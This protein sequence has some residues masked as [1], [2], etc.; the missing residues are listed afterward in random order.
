MALP[1]SYIWA[2]NNSTCRTKIA[3]GNVWVTFCSHIFCDPCGSKIFS[4]MTCIS[5]KSDVSGQ[6]KLHKKSLE[7]TVGWKKMVL[8]GLPPDTIMEICTSAIQFYYYQTTHQVSSMNARNMRLSERLNSVRQYY[9]G[10]V[11]QF[12]GQ[13]KSLESKIASETSRLTSS[14]TIDESI[15]NVDSNN[16]VGGCHWSASQTDMTYGGVTSN[17]AFAGVSRK[18]TFKCSSDPQFV[19][20]DTRSSKDYFT[21]PSSPLIRSDL[22][23]DYKPSQKIGDFSITQNESNSSRMSWN[24]SQELMSKKLKQTSYSQLPML[25]DKITG[26]RR[27]SRLALKEFDGGKVSGSKLVPYKTRRC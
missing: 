19:H 2:C 22:F 27:S 10:V 7:P 21:T 20:R 5:C 25:L 1:S 12:R 9:E 4:S 17:V 8:T 14:S 18:A 11:D 24:N 26:Q 23:D 16:F 3:S 6:F 15:L 13:V